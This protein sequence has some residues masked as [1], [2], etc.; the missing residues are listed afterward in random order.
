MDLLSAQVE[1]RAH[2]WETQRFV[3]GSGKECAEQRR[4]VG[5]Q[6]NR[7]IEGLHRL[8]EVCGGEVVAATGDAMV[9]DRAEPGQKVR[10]RRSAQGRS[11]GEKRG[12]VPEIREPGRKEA[13]EG[14][15]GVQP[16]FP[17]FDET[18]QL[19]RQGTGQ[20]V[21][22]QREDLETG[23]I[24]QG[25]G[26]G[27]AQSVP[28]QKQSLQR[29]EPTQVR[30]DRTREVVV[31]EPKLNELRQ[32]SEASG[33]LTREAIGIE[34]HELEAGEVAQLGWDRAGQGVELKRQN[35]E[36]GELTQFR[37]N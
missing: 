3:V 33:D 10:V 13:G 1:P 14:G 27:P 29:L 16:Q 35:A 36:S 5:D 15:V 17:Q 26:D 7:E 37:R 30:G 25:A 9:R 28:V 6:G 2:G 31:L 4:A 24:A 32:V 21:V 22:R 12:E 8:H 11:L 34:P 20:G 19:R 18:G 23:Q